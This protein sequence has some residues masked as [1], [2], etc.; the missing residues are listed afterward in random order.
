GINVVLDRQERTV[1][2]EHGDFGG[3]AHTGLLA[4]MLVGREASG[5]GVDTRVFL[6]E[7]RHER[8]AKN[9]GRVSGLEIPLI[10][11]LSDEQRVLE[12]VILIDDVQLEKAALET[13]QHHW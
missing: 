13:S 9:L 6:G 3:R 8:V 4:R 11:S 1:N 7:R 10:Q 5:I 12:R 2:S